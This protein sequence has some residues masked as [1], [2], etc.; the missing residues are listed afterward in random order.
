MLPERVKKRILAAIINSP[1]TGSK[2]PEETSFLMHI[3]F[4]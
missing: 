3:I 4:G 1:G 2:L